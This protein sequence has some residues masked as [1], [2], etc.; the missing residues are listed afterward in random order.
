MEKDL[1]LSA[2]KENTGVI[3]KAVVSLNNGFEEI[4]FLRIYIFMEGSAYF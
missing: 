2:G 3:S 1:L 4:L